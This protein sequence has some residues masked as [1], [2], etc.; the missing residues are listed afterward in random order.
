[1]STLKKKNLSHLFTLYCVCVCIHVG[2]GMSQ[3]A[4]RNWG[5]TIFGL[6]FSFS[7]LVSRDQTRVIRLSRKRF[8]PRSL[9]VSHVYTCSACWLPGEANGTSSLVW[10]NSISLPVPF[11]HGYIWAFSLSS[12]NNLQGPLFSCSSSHFHR[13]KLRPGPQ[14]SQTASLES[15]SRQSHIKSRAHKSPRVCACPLILCCFETVSLSPTA[16]LELTVL[17]PRASNSQRSSCLSF[18]HAI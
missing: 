1:M 13:S 15:K 18:P 5:I 16:G 11:L 4:C 2:S 10:M 8:Y 9:F 12:H 14:C 17:P 6:L 7:A 3:Q